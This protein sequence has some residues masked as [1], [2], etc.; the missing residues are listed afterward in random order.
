MARIKIRRYVIENRTISS[1][2]NS[3]I[4]INKSVDKI[5]LSLDKNRVKDYK[6]REGMI[7]KI[8]EMITNTKFYSII[9]KLS[10]DIKVIDD[11]VFKQD[12]TKD[13]VPQ[14]IKDEI[15]QDYLTENS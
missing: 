10:N 6:E 15:I 13:D 7:D 1:L 5:I 12:I 4:L 3:D 2:K 11:I 14:L 8:H 9:M